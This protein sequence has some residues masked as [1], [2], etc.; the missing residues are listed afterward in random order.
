[1]GWQN[2]AEG[3]IKEESVTLK[4]DKFWD[5]YINKSQPVV[6]RGLIMGSDAV[7]Q[8]TDIYLNRHYGQLEIQVTQRR[9]TF[10]SSLEETTTRMPLKKFLQNYR[11]EDW[12]LRGIIPDEM[13]AEASIPHLINCG[14]FVVDDST[15]ATSAGLSGEGAEELSSEKFR[16][17]LAKEILATRSQSEN[18][19]DYSMPKL[20]QLIEPYVWMSAG[21]T[22]SLLHSHPQ[23]NLHCVLDGR[24]DFIL[25][26]TD[27]FYARTTSTDPVK[28][29]QWRK[30]LDLYETFKNSDEW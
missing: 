16:S 8:W 3:P 24:K 15:P 5:D 1:M 25:I 22:S 27:Q 19:R 2:R 6:M 14:P 23:Q 29:N 4:A 10:R 11:V 30:Q 20:A 21:D 28:R 9:Q 13:L 18:E 12:Y 26:P 7:E 17:R